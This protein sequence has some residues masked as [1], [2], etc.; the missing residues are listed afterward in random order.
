ME[1]VLEEAYEE[2]DINRSGYDINHGGYDMHDIR[3]VR[4]LHPAHA[5]LKITNGYVPPPP[6]YFSSLHVEIAAIIVSM[7]TF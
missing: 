1:K 4:T 3:N 7:N 6:P 5:G 2:S